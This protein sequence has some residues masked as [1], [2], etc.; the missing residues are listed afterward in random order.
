MRIEINNRTKK[1]INSSFIKGLVNK[2]VAEYQVKGE[3][4]SIAFVSDAEIKKLNRIYRDKSEPTDILSF[5]GEGELWG[6]L[7][8]DYDQIK[9]QAGQFGNSAREE[10]IFILVHGLLH[11]LGYDDE[12]EKDRQ[13]MMEMGEQ[14]MENLKFCN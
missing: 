3:E 10:L 4:L 13:K 11:L 5:A 6:E 9:R 1:K 12:T 2:F 14:F 8:I 7:I